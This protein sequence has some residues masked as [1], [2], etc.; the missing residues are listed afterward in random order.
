MNNITILTG[1]I[2]VH[3]HIT[4]L[5]EHCPE[6][7][8][9]RCIMKSDLC[10]ETVEFHTA[11]YPGRRGM[12]IADSLKIDMKELIPY[13]EIIMRGK[14]PKVPAHSLR[15]CSLIYEFGAF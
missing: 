7:K 12:S 14:I 2:K 6:C 1:E 11:Y 4:A 8:D 9:T 10:T 15:S 3:E 13:F 5:Y